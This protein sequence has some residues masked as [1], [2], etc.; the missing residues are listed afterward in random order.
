[1]ISSHPP[2]CPLASWASLTCWRPAPRARSSSWTHP[3]TPLTPAGP[4]CLGGSQCPWG[5]QEDP[6][7]CPAPWM[8]CS[9]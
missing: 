9:S 2:V 5:L 6:G 7:G 3:E 1:M 8:V 4:R